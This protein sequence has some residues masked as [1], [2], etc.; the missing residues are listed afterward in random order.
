MVLTEIWSAPGVGKTHAAHEKWPNPLHL[1]TAFTKIGFR[2]LEV[3]PD[4][5]ETGESWEIVQKLHGWDAD[6]AREH[7]H[8]LEE[9][10]QTT[11]WIDSEFDTVIID[12][13]ADMRVLAA[14]HWCE[15][16]NSEWPKQ[17]EWSNVNDLIDEL[18]RVL[19]R[20]FNVVVVAQMKDEYQDGDKTGGKVRDSFKRMDY[21]ADIRLELELG[22]DNERHTW[23]RKNRYL[24]PSSG[25]YGAKGSDLG[26]DWDFEEL[27]LVS[28]VPDEVWL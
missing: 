28:D 8:Y 24:D 1:D 2:Q 18:L 22:D 10:P 21:K 5:N 15:Q 14:I 23:V 7:Y 17:A 11:E 13:A 9:F 27:M 25:A 19:N 3:E 20:D 26:S 4:P 6:E 12:N 16:N